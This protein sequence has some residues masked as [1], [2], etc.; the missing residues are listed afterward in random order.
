MVDVN[1]PLP[2]AAA[3][4]ER[5]A[6]P[7]RAVPGHR[8]APAAPGDPPGRQPGRLRAGGGAVSRHRHGTRQGKE[9]REMTVEA[10]DVSRLRQQISE[11]RLAARRLAALP[12]PQ[13]GALLK[14]LAAALEHPATRDRVLAAN[15]QDMSLAREDE[16][17]G[18]LG[19][20]LVKRLVLDE[21]KL[22]S[23]ADGLRQLAAHARAGGAAADP[24]PA[25][26]RPGARARHLPAGRAGGGVRGAPGSAGADHRAGLEERQ[27]RGAEGRARGPRT[28]TAPWPSWPA[29][30]WPN[31]GWTPAALVLLEERAEVDALLRLR[32]P[33]G[34]DRSPAARRRSSTTCAARAGS[35]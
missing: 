5:P 4:A 15:A 22:A 7:G 27:R 18:V 20:A 34:H 13:R 28:A 32:R 23:C 21:G 30:C 31:R 24:P 3:F 6:R 10:A 2:P 35:R 12:G 17:R 8:P 9:R 33:G 14:A 29:R 1:D 11:A 19:H 25:G 16:A 26:H